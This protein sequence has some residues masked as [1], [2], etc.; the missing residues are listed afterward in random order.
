MEDRRVMVNNMRKRLSK[1]C[2]LGK[3]AKCSASDDC[4]ELCGERTPVWS[5]HPEDIILKFY[6]LVFGSMT[7]S[8]NEHLSIIGSSGSQATKTR[9][10]TPTFNKAIK[11]EA[12]T[13][14]PDQKLKAEE[15]AQTPDQKLK[16]DAGKPRLSLVP[17]QIL[18]DVAAVREWATANKYPDPESWRKVEISRYREALLRHVLR[19]IDN[20]DGVD[21]ESGLPHLYHVATNCAFL[22]ELEKGN[23][24]LMEQEKNT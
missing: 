5:M 10:E 11:A 7:I 23:H 6:C 9:T 12:K 4:I 8:M 18:W 22:A 21:E 14:T 19:Y 15:K 16:A 2:S 3:C 17:M 1:H 13:Q 20:P 24:P